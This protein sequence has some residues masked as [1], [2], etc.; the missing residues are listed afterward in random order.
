MIEAVNIF[1]VAIEDGRIDVAGAA[2]ST[3]AAMY[4]T[5]IAPGE[6]AS[7]YHY[8]YVEEWLLVVTESVVVRTPGGERALRAGQLVRFPS[9]PSGA[10]KIMNRG[11]APAR[12]LLMSRAA[13]PAVSVYPD[14]NKIGIW[15]GESADDGIFVRD[16]AVPWSHGEEGWHLAD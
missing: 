10:H 12:L 8:E 5:E 1:E 15:P 16:S 11:D 2:V 4:L 7:P 14:S 6:S 9:G 13:V 3:E